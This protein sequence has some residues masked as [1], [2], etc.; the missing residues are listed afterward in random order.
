MLLGCILT[1]RNK[2]QLN[3]ITGDDINSSGRRIPT[4]IQL[5]NKTI[6]ELHTVEHG[7]LRVVSTSWH[8]R[9]VLQISAGEAY[10]K[11]LYLWVQITLI[12]YAVKCVSK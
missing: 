9:S 7:V 12:S 4:A 5:N 6:T 10:Y 11:G 2:L 8:A 1:I 3:F